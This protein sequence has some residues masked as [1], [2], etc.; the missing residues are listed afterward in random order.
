MF[1]H[2]KYLSGDLFLKVFHGLM[3]FIYISCSSNCYYV[4]E[5][6][7]FFSPVLIAQ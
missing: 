3:L 2:M 1:T 6:A 4:V 5:K 7:V